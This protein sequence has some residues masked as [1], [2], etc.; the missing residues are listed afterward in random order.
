MKKF[1]IAGSSL[2][3]VA[4]AGSAGAVDVTLGGSIDMGVEYGV[5]KD[6]TSGFG[7]GDNYQS[8]SISVAAAGTTDAGLKFGGSFSISTADELAFNPYAGDDSYNK[9]AMKLV[10]SDADVALR[11]IGYNVSG[12]APVTPG[13]MVSVKINSEWHAAGSTI[14]AYDVGFDVDR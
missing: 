9:Y 10:N 6:T 13:S 2:A 11:G 3:A 1:L 8:I 14:T 12:G 7:I 4:A 5:G